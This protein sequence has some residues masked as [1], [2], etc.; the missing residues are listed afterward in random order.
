MSL[1]PSV[2]VLLTLGC[3]RCT[4]Q[5]ATTSSSTMPVGPALS[6]TTA[7]ASPS[8][9]APTTSPLTTSPPSSPAPIEPVVDDGWSPTVDG[10]RG[11]LIATKTKDANGRAE[12][13][14]DL[15]LDNVSSSKKPVEIWWGDFNEMLHFALDDQTGKELPGDAAGGNYLSGPPHW[16]TVASGKP[17]RLTISETSYEYVPSGVTLFRP[18]TFQSWEVSKNAASKMFARA[19]LTP[20]KIPIPPA[21]AAGHHG[22][23]GSLDL[24]R[25]QVR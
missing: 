6:S 2:S 15:E 16:L 1:F 10:L 4:A 22:F 8:L 7:V 9:S 25:I 24:P 11:R 18:L 13:K 19:S 21:D 3:V 5:S 17:V 14:L 12:L 23:S 20:S